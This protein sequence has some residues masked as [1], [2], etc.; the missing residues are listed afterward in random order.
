MI[1]DHVNAIR[2]NIGAL[3]KVKVKMYRDVHNF[4]TL[5]FMQ[6]NET[7]LC[8]F[9]CSHIRRR[10]TKYHWEKVLWM[11]AD[12]MNYLIIEVM[13]LKVSF[14]LFLFQEIEKFRSLA[15]DINSLPTVAHFDMVQLDCDDLKR[16]LATK[17]NRF[18]D[19]L[20]QRL[21]EEH[22]AENRRWK[23]ILWVAVGYYIQKLMTTF[24]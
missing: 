15:R 18:A 22:R 1:S 7:K 20:L 24:L 3:F 14:S 13:L 17:A 21:A 9:N 23:S 12:C 5:G 4:K 2:E 10:S 19:Q 16:G 8:H 6:S 11:Y